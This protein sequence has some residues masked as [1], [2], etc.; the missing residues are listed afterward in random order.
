MNEEQMILLLRRVFGWV[1]HTYT[2][3]F[4]EACVA[5][6]DRCAIT[7]AITELEA[8]I[9]TFQSSKRAEDYNKALSEAAMYGNGVRFWIRDNDPVT[10]AKLARTAAR[11]G[12]RAL[13]IREG[14]K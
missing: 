13:A 2:D 10:A 3:T 1:P 4:G 14:G 8:S 6:C 12:L 9:T 7:K 11:W 5:E